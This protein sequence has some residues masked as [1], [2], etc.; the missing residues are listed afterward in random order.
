MIYVSTLPYGQESFTNWTDAS[1]RA[2]YLAEELLLRITIEV[3][4]EESPTVAKRNTPTT[5]KR[6]K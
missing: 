3:E 2:K 4:P 1:V 6:E 5:G